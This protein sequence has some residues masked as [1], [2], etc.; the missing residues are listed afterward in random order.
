MMLLGHTFHSVVHPATQMSFSESVGLI[1]TTPQTEKEKLEAEGEVQLCKLASSLEGDF[2]GVIVLSSRQAFIKYWQLGL[3]LYSYFLCS[4][5]NLLG[6]SPGHQQ[7]ESLKVTVLY[8]ISNCWPI[9][10]AVSELFSLSFFRFTS[11]DHHKLYITVH[12]HR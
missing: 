3:C 9:L 10:S 8:S 12:G 4:C 5:G 11:L 1:A 2:G 6:C 7:G